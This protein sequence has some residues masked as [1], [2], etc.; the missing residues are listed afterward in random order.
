[1]GIFSIFK[2]TSKVIEA[3]TNDAL[4]KIEKSNPLVMANQAIRD[5]E[6][7][8]Q[9]AVSASATVKTN[10]VKCESDVKSVEES[11]AT[12]QKQADKLKVK[13]KELAT[14][15][16]KDG[17]SDADKTSIGTSI[18]GIKGHVGEAIDNINQLK[19]TLDQKKERALKSK[20]RSETMKKRLKT[21]TK[22]IKN[23]KDTL[24]DMKAQTEMAE[25]ELKMNKNMNSSVGDSAQAMFDK[26]KESADNMEAEAEAY[27]DLA[28]NNKSAQ[29]EIDDILNTP[30][31]GAATKKADDFLN[32]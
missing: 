25:A 15:L 19:V 11:I 9:D 21:L 24:I 30:T 1:M 27:G 7:E 16:A 23:A 13:Y 10:H 18:E 28:D 31:P 5:M 8:Y 29:D 4:D 26:M 17:I 32:S 12:W 20:Q 2:K 22:N 14:A 3:H 6:K